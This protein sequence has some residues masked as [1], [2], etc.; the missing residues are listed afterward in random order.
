MS[1]IKKICNRCSL[2]VANLSYENKRKYLIKKGAN[3]GIG[4]RMNCNVDAFGIK[5]SR[6]F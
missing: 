3:I 5:R 4:T 6:I 1:I 2:L